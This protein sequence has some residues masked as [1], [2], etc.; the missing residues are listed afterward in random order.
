MDALTLATPAGAPG[1]L[2]TAADVCRGVHHYVH[3]YFNDAGEARELL[4][5]WKV[6]T[7]EDIGRV[8]FAAVDAGLLRAR[9]GES[10]RDFDGLYTLDTLLTEPDDV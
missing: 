5:E 7:S 4:T 1:D 3:A 9:P 6:A 10:V 8:I 2:L